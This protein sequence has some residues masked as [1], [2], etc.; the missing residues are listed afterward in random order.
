MNKPKV[1]ADK[2]NIFSVLFLTTSRPL[3]R[4]ELLDPN[5]PSSPLVPAVPAPGTGSV[6]RKPG[7]PSPR[8]DLMVRVRY[9]T[10]VVKNFSLT[11]YRLPVSL[12]D[13]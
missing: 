10:T 12:T 11:S 5:S 6:V 3:E 9:W 2:L 13:T 8:S 4:Q 1:C 7:R